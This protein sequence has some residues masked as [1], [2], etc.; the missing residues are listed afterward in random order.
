MAIAQMNWGRMLHS[1][2][3]PRMSEFSD[4]LER[5]YKDAE[6][7]PGFRWRISDE[8]AAVQLEQLGFDDKVSATVSVWDSVDALRAY[9]YETEHGVFL[10]RAKEWFEKVEGPQLVIWPV[11]G[12]A[13][14]TFAEAF[15]RLERLRKEGPTDAAYAW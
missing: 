9:T 4:A 1:L 11:E 3:D 12:L 5:V 14:P 7:H 6:N 13:M 15:A 2:S 8:A 10:R